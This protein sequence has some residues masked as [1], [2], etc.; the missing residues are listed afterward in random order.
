MQGIVIQPGGNGEVEQ[1][2]LR[3]V[4]ELMCLAARTAPKA[5]GTDNLVAA[6]VTGEA[7]ER[8]AAEMRAIAE[9]VNAAF[10]ARDAANVDASPVVVLLG[11]RLMR[12]GLP[13]CGLCSFADCK[14]NEEAGAVCVFPAH[15]L[16]IAVG[17]AAGV[18]AD[19]HVDSRVM[20]SAGAAALRLGLLGDEARI[21]FGIPL[22]AGGKSPFF[23]RKQS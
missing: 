1:R 10:F 9:E 15:D 8:L 23:D 16:G 14:K 22:S 18:A 11:T 19:H 2:A 5:R 4:A 12:F 6:V 17:S 13:A 21:A 3:T 20:F 7:K